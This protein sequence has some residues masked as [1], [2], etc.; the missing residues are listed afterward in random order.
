MAY[1]STKKQITTFE[2]RIHWNINIRKKNIFFAYSL[3]KK[4]KKTIAQCQLC[5]VQGLIS[6]RKTP[7]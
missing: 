3:R 1:F 6:Q 5:F 2:Y 4:I 7:A